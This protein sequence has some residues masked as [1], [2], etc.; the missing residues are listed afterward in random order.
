MVKDGPQVHR[1]CPDS[2]RALKANAWKLDKIAVFS[3]DLRDGIKGSVLKT[4]TVAL[5]VGK[6]VWKLQ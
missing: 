3:D 4:V 5:P 2:V 6:K 1:H